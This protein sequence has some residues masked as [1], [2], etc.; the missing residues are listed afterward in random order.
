M[1]N[2]WKSASDWQQILSHMT[3]KISHNLE[4]SRF[5]EWNANTTYPHSSTAVGPCLQ[6]YAP[7]FNTLCKPIWLVMKPIWKQ[8]NLLGQF[9]LWSG[10]GDQL[11]QLAIALT[12]FFW[13]ASNIVNV[14][15]HDSHALLIWATISFCCFFGKAVVNNYLR[16]Y[17]APFCLLPM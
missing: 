5:T 15:N 11:L 1:W 3:T 13:I 9:L 2:L 12:I 4:I 17:C 14:S 8:K 10:E 16:V 6:S 7:S